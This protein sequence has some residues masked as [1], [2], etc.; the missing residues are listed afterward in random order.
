[1]F[2]ES[3]EGFIRAKDFAKLLS[4]SKTTFWRKVKS[5][6]IEPGF[7]LGTNIRAWNKTYV[8]KFINSLITN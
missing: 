3:L 5:G 7:K 4:I 6:E 8:K 2:T 1:M